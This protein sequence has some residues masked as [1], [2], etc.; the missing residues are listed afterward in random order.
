MFSAAFGRKKEENRDELK[1]DFLFYDF[2]T[3]QSELWKGAKKMHFARKII[4]FPEDSP[5]VASATSTSSR[6]NNNFAIAEKTVQ[7]PGTVSSRL[8]AEMIDILEY[9]KFQDDREKSIAYQQNLRR[10]LNLK[11]YRQSTLNSDTTQEKTVAVAENIEND[12]VNNN[13]RNDNATIDNDNEE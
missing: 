2:E 7:T 6:N 1:V 13:N 9:H 12:K 5:I 4:L 11:S 3:T 10:F 8:N